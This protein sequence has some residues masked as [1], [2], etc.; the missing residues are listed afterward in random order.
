MTKREKQLNDYVS[1]NKIDSI[2]S[3]VEFINDEIRNLDNERF[4]LLARLFHL[5]NL[6]SLKD[7]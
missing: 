2:K 1:D 5:Q 3:R 4:Y 6:E 7:G